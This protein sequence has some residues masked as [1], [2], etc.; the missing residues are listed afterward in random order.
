VG[1]DAGCR[2][3]DVNGLVTDDVFVAGDVSRFPHPLYDYQF[4]ALEHWGNAVAQAEVAAHNMISEPAGRW[5]HVASPV[6]WSAQFGTNIKSVGVP[7]LADHVVV[8]QGS[9]ADRRFVAVYGYRGR[10]IGMVGFDQARWVE[11]YQALIENAAPFPPGPLPDDRQPVP[12]GFLERGTRNLHAT[13]AVTG[14]DPSER[15]ARLIH[16]RD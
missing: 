14:H 7:T 9:V 1:C 11:H 6:F 12:A 8:T 2:A 13:V 16:H 5:P 10:T 4:L 15:R 3:F